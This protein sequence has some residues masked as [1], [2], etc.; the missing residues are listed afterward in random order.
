MLLGLQ[1]CFRVLQLSRTSKVKECRASLDVAI[2]RG[3]TCF[4]TKLLLL[5]ILGS[6]LC[7]HLLKLNLEPL[8]GQLYGSGV[9]SIRR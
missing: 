3:C 6:Q 2:R 5:M 4:R 9:R 7:S 8:R 1:L